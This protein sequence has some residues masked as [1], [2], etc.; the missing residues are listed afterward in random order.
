MPKFLPTA[1]RQ[2]PKLKI[3]VKADV[4]VQL[5]RISSKP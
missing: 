3:K 1:G 4:E 5:E 2:I